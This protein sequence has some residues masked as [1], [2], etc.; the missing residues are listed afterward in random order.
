MSKNAVALFSAC[1]S[2]LYMKSGKVK[3]AFAHDT[4]CSPQKTRKRREDLVLQQVQVIHRHGAR[5]PIS[6][7]KC[8]PDLRFGPR[9]MDH[10][11]HTFVPY[12]IVA[13]DGSSFDASNLRGSSEEFIGQ[14]SGIGAQQLYDVGQMLQKIYVEDL[15]FI[16]SE[17]SPNEV[18]VTSTKFRR[19]VESARSLLAGL[20]PNQTSEIPLVV[21]RE[22][23]LAPSFRSCQVLKLVSAMS[24][25]H[26][27]IVTGVKEVREKLQKMM[28]IPE[29]DKSFHIVLVRD[30]LFSYQF[31]SV[32][33]SQYNQQM[34]DVA[35]IG[36]MKV[37]NHVFT[38]ADGKQSVNI[39]RLSLG[40]F[41]NR[42]LNNMD[43]CT[44][45]ITEEQ[46]KKEA[47]MLLYSGHDTTLIPLL[48][49]LDVYDG[50]WP[51]FASHVIIELYRDEDIINRSLNPGSEEGFFVRVIYNNEEQ[52]LPGCNG[53]ALCPLEEF[54]KALSV[55]AI[56]QCEYD[57]DCKLC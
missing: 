46:K 18:K 30:A 39:L 12:K 21:D 4:N 3:Q 37:M 45:A 13:S 16:S 44:L 50:K 26:P 38:G 35:E 23:I 51:P 15:K 11:I 31:H 40:R 53:Q 47:K 52:K 33:P 10:P 28:N 27:D 49:I 48:S 54:K 57:R 29:D 43:K 9:I 8:L 20:Y 41:I 19:T 34:L 24:W 17:F 14:L 36:A 56:N 1:G 32:L 7:P 5:A 22:E 6:S 25:D 2:Y 55:Y 42:L